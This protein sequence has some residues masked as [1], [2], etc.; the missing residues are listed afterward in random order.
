MTSYTRTEVATF[1]GIPEGELTFTHIEQFEK[2]K[3]DSMEKM[4]ES[5]LSEAPVGKLETIEFTDLI[6]GKKI[7]LDDIEKAA[8]QIQED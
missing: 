7:S 2:M 5:T 6:K 3:I 4:L 1:F 8:S